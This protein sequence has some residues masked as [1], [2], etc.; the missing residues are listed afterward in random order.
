MISKHGFPLICHYDQGC[1]LTPSRRSMVGTFAVG[2]VMYVRLSAPQSPI[3]NW[4]CHFVFTTGRLCVK[5]SWRSVIL[6]SIIGQE[7]QIE[8]SCPYD[9]NESIPRECN[10]DIVGIFSISSIFLVSASTLFLVVYVQTAP[11]DRDDCP[12]NVRRLFSHVVS[13]TVLCICI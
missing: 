1:K 11:W 7:L 10:L 6:A 2:P 4:F 12:S 9:C 5:H 8:R 3:P 13:F